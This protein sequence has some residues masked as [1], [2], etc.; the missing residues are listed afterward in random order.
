MCIH[1]SLPKTVVFYTRECEE[2]KVWFVLAWH[3]F[4]NTGPTADECEEIHP[5]NPCVAGWEDMYP[6]WDGEGL[7][8]AIGAIFCTMIDQSRGGEGPN[9]V[10]FSEIGTKESGERSC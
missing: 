5:S 6:K 4:C 7:I 1:K 8:H 10:C 2:Y 3:L 9:I